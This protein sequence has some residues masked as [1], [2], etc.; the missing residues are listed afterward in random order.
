METSDAAAEEAK[1]SEKEPE[2]V[3]DNSSRSIKKVWR[4]EKFLR[5]QQKRP[6]KYDL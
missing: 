6:F 5:S 1:Q 2:I 3:K 4:I